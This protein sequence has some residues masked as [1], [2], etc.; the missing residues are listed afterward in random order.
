MVT[1]ADNRSQD[2]RIKRKFYDSISHEFN[3]L[4]VKSEIYT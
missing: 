4:M 2:K 3:H 1:G